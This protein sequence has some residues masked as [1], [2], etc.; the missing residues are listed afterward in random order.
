MLK[1]LLSL[2][3]VVLLSACSS[4]SNIEKTSKPA[5]LLANLIASNTKNAMEIHQLSKKMVEQKKWQNAFDGYLWLCS[6]TV[7]KQALFCTLMWSSAQQSKVSVNL[8]VAAATNYTIYKTNYWLIQTKKFAE[9]ENQQSI[10]KTLQKYP[11]TEPQLAKLASSPKHYAQALFIKG[12]LKRNPVLLKQAKLLFIHQKNWLAAADTMMLISQLS[13][14]AEQILVASKNYNRALL[15]YDLAEAK[16][17]L[18][19]AITWGKEHGFAR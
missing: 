2:S 15:Y 14:T 12:K 4:N 13:L 18:N 6:R 7:K 5:L 1:E 16:N 8:F 10:I 9:T 19:I 11:L 3:L 17:K